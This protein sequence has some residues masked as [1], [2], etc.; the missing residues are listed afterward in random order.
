MTES[1]NEFSTPRT[2]KGYRIKKL[3]Y[4]L[5]KSEEK[6]GK[7]GLRCESALSEDKASGKVD[8]EIEF[9]SDKTSENKINGC[10][11]IEGYFELSDKLND[12][13]KKMYVQQNGAAMLYPYARTIVSMI[14]SFDDS[15]VGILPTINFVN[16]AN[17]EE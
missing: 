11:E 14:T 15:K 6:V 7:S 13:D 2:F 17:K 8:I 3:E 1:N 12:D 5:K 4:Y 16:L 9:N 10:L